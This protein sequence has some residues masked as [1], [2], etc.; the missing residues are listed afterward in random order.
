MTLESHLGSLSFSSLEKN[1]VLNSKSSKK[2]GMCIQDKKLYP[3]KLF[4]IVI[5]HQ[6]KQIVSMFS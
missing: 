2:T 5:M 1:I 3:I 4:V 6:S